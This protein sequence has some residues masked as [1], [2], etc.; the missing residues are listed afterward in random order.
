MEENEMKQSICKVA[1]LVVDV[2]CDV[3]GGSRLHKQMVLYVI[4]QNIV[5]RDQV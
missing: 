2:N 5:N 4:D 1:H 3:F